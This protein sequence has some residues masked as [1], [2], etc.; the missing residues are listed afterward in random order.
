MVRQAHHDTFSMSLPVRLTLRF[1]LTILLVWGMN[2]V[3]DEYMFVGGGWVGYAV[4]GALLTLLNLFVRPMLD[5][6]TLPLKFLA[7]LLAIILVNAM[8]LWI[9]QEISVLFDPN[10][11]SLTMTG[12]FGGWVVVSLVLG[13]A[14]WLMKE[15][16]R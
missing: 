15:L 7:T 10:I 11:V 13:F 9:V 16:L 6:V 12:G 8:F 4:I 1:V 2:I 5:L 3:I 14:N